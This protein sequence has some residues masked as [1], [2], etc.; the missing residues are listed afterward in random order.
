MIVVIPVQID[1]YLKNERNITLIQFNKFT[2]N[3][4]ITWYV[5]V[6]FW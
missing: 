5:D 6:L 2:H 4:I 3:I 1:K